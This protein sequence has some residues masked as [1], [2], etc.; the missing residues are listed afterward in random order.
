MLT[1][2]PTT[3][4]NDDHRNV[5]TATS[6]PLPFL[7][8]LEG[9]R[10]LAALYVVLFHVRIRIEPQYAAFGPVVDLLP[11]RGQFLL[12]GHYAVGI[13]IVISGFVLTLPIAV[14]GS[15]VGGWRGFLK[16]RARRLLPA[17]Y[18][19]LTLSVPFY[20]WRAQYEGTPHSALTVVGQYLAHVLLVHDLNQHT[21]WGINS[22]LWS[23]A[24]EVQIYVL[25]ILVL[26]PLLL[27]RGLMTAIGAAFAIG[28]LP[29]IYAALR[30]VDSATADRAS[31]WFLGLF[32]L[33]SAAALVAYDASDRYARIRTGFPWKTLALSSG[34]AFLVLLVRLPPNDPAGIGSLLD[35]L[36]GI[37]A[38][39]GFL[40]IANDQRAGRRSLV[41]TILGW[42]P[43]VVL[44]TF[45]YSLYLIHDPLVLPAM[46]YLALVPPALRLTLAFGVVVPGIVGLAYLFARMFEFPFVS[47]TR[48]SV[49]HAPESRVEVPAAAPISG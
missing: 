20:L 29:S 8:Y 38:A 49:K 18:A 27:R 41:A 28:Y 24:V 9:L 21:I 17:Y 11:F 43:F 46:H 3:D 47:A 2:D 22:P 15:L 37:S 48:R 32:A 16:R 19:A 36:L 25:F 39:S 10:G 7:P 13:F 34:I 31:F 45:S 35:V 44:G 5:R 40:A 23:V 6:A 14:R 1:C 4:T 12:Y 33:G 30:H 26:L 42:R